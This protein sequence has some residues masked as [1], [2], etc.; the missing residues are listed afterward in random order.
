MSFTLHFPSFLFPPLT[1]QLLL[2][3][4]FPKSVS[5]CL[6]VFVT[7]L[8]SFLITLCDPNRL[9]VTWSDLTWALF[10]FTYQFFRFC[11]QFSNSFC[12]LNHPSPPCL[13]PSSSQWPRRVTCFY[14]TWPDL[15]SAP[16][17]SPQN[18]ISFYILTSPSFPIRRRAFPVE[19]SK[20]N[21]TIFF[22]IILKQQ[23]SLAK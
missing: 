18:P 13:L 5:L 8:L 22:V 3:S 2:R 6:S 4:H 1:Y 16:P 20:E 19:F 9:C 10:F 14:L 7:F 12:Y 23:N 15:P 21:K 11:F 17:V